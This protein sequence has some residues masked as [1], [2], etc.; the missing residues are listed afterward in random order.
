MLWL[1]VFTPDQVHTLKYPRR[2]SVRH[3]S[4]RGVFSGRTNP[5]FESLLRLICVWVILREHIFTSYVP[6]LFAFGH[7]F[8]FNQFVAL[9][10]ACAV[11]K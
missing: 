10:A 7:F 11:I 2:P 1:L 9:K 4:R 5:Y 3:H 6:H 8:P